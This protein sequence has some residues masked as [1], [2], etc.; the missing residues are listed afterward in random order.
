M[1]H[2]C[3]SIG[4]E[5]SPQVE[6]ES[7]RAVIAAAAD[8]YREILWRGKHARIPRSYLRRRGLRESVIRRFGVGYAPIGWTGVIDHLVGLGYE[9]DEIQAVGLASRSHRRDDRHYDVFRSRLMFPIFDP[10]R[11]I[12]GFAGRGTHPGP[13][14]P[15]WVI[16]QN[17]S[18]FQAERA[19]F[20]LE[21]AASAISDTG[22]VL[23][24]RD[25]LDVLHNFQQGRL[26]TVAVIRSRV[27]DQHRS[28][29]SRYGGDEVRTP[30]SRDRWAPRSGFGW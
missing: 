14:W 20:G 4:D 23:I 2:R 17:G 21:Q 27:T 3:I 26:A 16:S 9:R 15:R 6:P 10:E 13:S 28:V 5:R 1:A 8:Y 11:G 18:T 7:G 29:L 24:L 30:S 12:V 19:I 25:C 22:E